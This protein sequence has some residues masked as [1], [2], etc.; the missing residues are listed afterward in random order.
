MNTIKAVGKK[1]LSEPRLAASATVAV[2]AVVVAFVGA[3]RSRVAFDDWVVVAVVFFLVKIF[4]LQSD[5]ALGLVERIWP[6]VV[7]RIP[8]R[9]ARAALTIDDVPLLANPTQLEEILD[10]LKKHSVTATFFIMSGFDMSEEEGGLPMEQ[11]Q[12][13]R[14]L[15]QRAVAEGHELGNHLQF[16]RPAFAMSREEFEQAFLHC[17]ALLA[18]MHGGAA[19]WKARPRRWF[20]PASVIW[21]EHIL[22]LASAHGYT[23]VIANCYP[24][25]VASVTRHI[26][27]A[28]LSWRARPGA[29]IVVHDRWHTPATLQK[30][31]PRIALKGMALCTLSELQAAANSEQKK[32][33][34]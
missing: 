18:D 25:D 28:Y 34:Q 32:K 10:T 19:A 22:A 23:T 6:Q 33:G 12:Q 4:Y 15:L 31:L 20:R 16:D 5:Y 27:A 17:D 29:I 3:A 11:R 8:T 7:W 24:H 26:N 13:F 2:L 21:N 30:A 1:T 9:E 14:A